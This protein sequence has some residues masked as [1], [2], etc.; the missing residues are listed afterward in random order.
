[1]ELRDSVAIVTGASRGIGVHIADALARRG[2]HLALAAR[3]EPE[4]EAVAERLRSR[5]VKV[6]SVATDVSDRAALERLVERTSVELGP[7]DVLVNNAG[8]EIAG[9]S[10]ELDLD[11]IDY[12]VN[13]NLTSLIQLSRLVLP[14]MIERRRGHICNIASAAGLVAR[15]YAT[16]YSATKHGVVGFSWSLRAE[17]APHNVEVS[18]ICPSYVSD[19][20]MFADRSSALGAG[21][22]PPALRTVTPTKVA[23]ETIRSIERNR[24]QS[25]VGPLLMKIGGPVH[26]IAPDLG[27][28]VGR[29]SGLYRFIKKEATGD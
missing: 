21:K 13:V 3:S 16:V 22:P 25:V 5:G 14:I 8:L 26:S 20:G 29:R 4:L 24:A 12:V 17:V 11:R 7:V 9:Y 2:S 1:M 19:V 6:I 15:P 27:I 10:H 23:E 18:V 28:G